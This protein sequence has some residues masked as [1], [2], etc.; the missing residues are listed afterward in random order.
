[1]GE[2]RGDSILNP[3][4]PIVPPLKGPI[5]VIHSIYL[6]RELVWA[7]VK[8]NMRT[9]YRTASLGYLW[10]VLEPSLLAITYYFLFIM[11]A[12]NP[13]E[14]YP[15]WVLVGVIVWS[16]FGKSLSGT[17]SSISSNAQTINMAYFPRIIFPVSITGGHI[18]TSLG[19]S[20]VVL[21]I[22]IYFGTP[23]T[24]NLIY[25]PIGVIMA[26]IMGGSFG[27][28]FASINCKQRDIEHLFR[29]IV[30]A[31]FFFSPVMWTAEMALERGTMGEAALYNPMTTPI[32]MV[33]HAIDGQA[34]SLPQYAV[35]SSIIFLLASMIIGSMIFTKYE[36][37]AVKFL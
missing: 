1:M 5:N 36:R 9:R 30:R 29:F 17:V 14:L 27:L 35:F 10:L 11:L 13:D 18:I 8:R 20:L 25:V 19:S 2:D 6:N 33:R 23:V 34:L 12:G 7:M 28:I 22:I 3:V 4:A 31:G 21:P 16:T 24:L 37:E 15:V 32:T 26:G